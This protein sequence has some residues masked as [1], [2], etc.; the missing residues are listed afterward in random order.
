MTVKEGVYA[1]EPPGAQLRSFQ[2]EDVSTVCSQVF[3]AR[4]QTHLRSG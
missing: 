4:G 2:Q 1:H 3:A